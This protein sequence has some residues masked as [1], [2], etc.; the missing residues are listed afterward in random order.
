LQGVFMAIL[1]ELFQLDGIIAVGTIDDRGRIKDWKAKGV[2]TPEVRESMDK[3]MTSAVALVDQEARILPR[4]WSPR[5]SWTFSGGDMVLI[6]AGGQFVTA[7]T[8]KVD[9]E[10]LLRICGILPQTKK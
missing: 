1:D 9:L 3:F 5:R 6:V 8:G 2:I 7:E 10:R 4:N